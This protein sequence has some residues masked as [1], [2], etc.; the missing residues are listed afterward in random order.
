MEWRRS[1]AVAG[2]AVAGAGHA[3]ILESMR[4]DGPGVPLPLGDASKWN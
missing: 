3:K 1:G 2:V 4:D